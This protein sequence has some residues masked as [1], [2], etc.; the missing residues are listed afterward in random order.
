MKKILTLIGSSVLF[1]MTF[2]SAQAS[3]VNDLVLMTEQY[4]PF[5]FEKDKKLMGIS[6]DLMEEILKRSK[7]SLTRKDF[8]LLPWSRAYKTAQKKKN[9]VV[10]ATTRTKERENLFS[11]VG[12][13]TDTRIVIISKKGAK[14]KISSLEDIKKNKKVKIGVIRDDIGEQLLLKGGIDIKQL[15]RV[16]RTDANVSK[17]VKG[18]IHGWAYAE[19][20]AY[21]EL[22]NT[23]GVKVS[24]YETSLVLKEGELWYAFNK[25]TDKAILKT[26]QSAVDSIVSDGTHKSIVDRYMN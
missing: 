22:K 16:S 19:K 8:K 25:G 10:F 12:P 20:V 26:L 5:N 13:I 15:D 4:P 2:S 24:D 9:H 3:S 14:T 17:L 7:S 11:W 18:R 6:V 1:F 21:H 23:K